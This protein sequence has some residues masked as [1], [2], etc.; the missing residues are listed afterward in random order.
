MCHQSPRENRLYRR[1]SPNLAL[2]ESEAWLWA[3]GRAKRSA[4]RVRALL[5][6]S[7]GWGSVTHPSVTLLRAVRLKGDSKQL[8][9]LHIVLGSVGLECASKTRRDAEVERDNLLA[10][11]AGILRVALP[12]SPSGRSQLGAA[13]R[14]VRR[15][16]R[17]AFHMQK[18]K[19]WC[20]PPPWEWLSRTF[21]AGEA[22]REP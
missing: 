8:V 16:G 19:Q 9:E 6:T 2:P 5:W 12:A 10:S 4:T 21:G 18:G 15:R 3:T 13:C 11:S 17:P 20:G 22:V 14:R 7:R 1:Q